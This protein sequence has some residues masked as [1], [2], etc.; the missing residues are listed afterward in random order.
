MSER[1]EPSEKRMPPE[2]RKEVMV[3]FQAIPGG[4]VGPS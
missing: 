1:I 3:G 4:G 2:G